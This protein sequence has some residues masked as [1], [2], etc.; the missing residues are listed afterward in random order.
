[1][2]AEMI[3]VKEQFWSEDHNCGEKRCQ[4]QEAWGRGG[5]RRGTMRRSLSGEQKPRGQYPD[6]DEI[7][8]VPVARL[9]PPTA[10]AVF[11]GVRISR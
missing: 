3:M 11:F 7:V 10:S 4:C 9:S 1:M 6:E 5:D 8:S 2:A